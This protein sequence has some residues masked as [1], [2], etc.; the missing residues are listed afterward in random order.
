MDER[1]RE[2]IDA[3][4]F[5]L[6]EPGPQAEALRA[7]EAAGAEAIA[8]L[9]EARRMRDDLSAWHD[10]ADAFAE[11][12]G[13]LL[14]RLSAPTETPTV[15][16]APKESA[17]SEEPGVAAVRPVRRFGP[18][19]WAAAIAAAITLAVTLGFYQYNA[20]RRPGSL[21]A[22]VDYPQYLAIDAR[23]SIRV[24][25]FDAVDELESTPVAGA[26]VRA[27]L[28]PAGDDE[29]EFALGTFTTDAGGAADVAFST[30][31]F[32]PG[33]YRLV[34]DTRTRRRVA[35]LT[36][37]VML[38]RPFTVLPGTDKPV[39]RP[40]ETV[41]VRAVVLARP[42]GRP[43][44]GRLVRFEL[45]E[46]GGDRTPV[47]ATA[48]TGAFGIAAAELRTP[49]AYAPGFV[50][51]V[52]R[53]EDEQG[54]P[55]VS[56]VPIFV[57]E[58]ERP[59]AA[60]EL[61]P[62]KPYFLRG[63]AV[64]GSVR[65][66]DFQGRPLAGAAVSITL[67]APSV[68]A[69]PVEFRA[70]ADAG[71]NAAF[72]LVPG[73]AHRGEADPENP[74]RYLLRAEVRDV[75]GGRVLGR[76][77]RVITLA[78]S[79]LVIR[80]LP[81]GGRIVPGV[82]NR[83]LIAVA[84]PDGAPVE[85]EIEFGGVR[86]RAD[87]AT[88]VSFTP[89]E[90][91]PRVVITA[92]SGADRTRR[93]WSARAAE[94]AEFL[95][96]PSRTTFAAGTTLTADLMA[97]F[98]AG[99]VIVD[100]LH[101]EQWLL[102]GGSVEITAG[103]GR[104]EWDVPAELS[105]PVVLRAHRPGPEGEAAAVERRVVFVV[106]SNDVTLRLEPSQPAYRPGQDGAIAVTVRDAGG[107]AVPAAIGA[108]VFDASLRGV[109]EHRIEAL[110]QHL[111]IEDRLARGYLGVRAGRMSESAL[112]SAELERRAATAAGTADRLHGDSYDRYRYRF[113]QN[114]R[115]WMRPLLAGAFAAALVLLLTVGSAL[116]R[117]GRA[118][119][120][121]MLAASVAVGGFFLFQSR[122]IPEMPVR[123]V[124]PTPVVPNPGRGPASP[125]PFDRIISPDWQVALAQPA[126][127][128]LWVPELTT[129][130][131][132][133]ASIRFVARAPLPGSRW[134]GAITAITEDGGLGTAEIEI[135]VR[136]N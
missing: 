26:E 29:V 89:R 76:A 43:A 54:Y 67:A 79:P 73:D 125:G 74:R 111:S 47:S 39:Y 129:D 4:A 52:A 53:V 121:G 106:P 114:R 37:E 65:V 28:R 50:E 35:Q 34:V 113:E 18:W 27:A 97:A 105:G 30:A 1:L 9:E 112:A 87:G 117:A 80:V 36:R 131:H 64:E 115:G 15:A 92:V 95:L 98:P 6:L 83:V 20:V 90:P 110:Q 59:L 44:A 102:G 56:A 75:V 82:E 21:R 42:S 33:R 93:E 104:F 12:E 68:E 58:H 61:T 11:A 25:V 96:R 14:A 108:A 91:N 123:P 107:R 2:Q 127:S 5:G 128:L 134:T 31:G 49:A 132:G 45:R 7:I 116:P 22:Q 70:V 124:E 13:R 86:A 78:D 135:P 55:A 85:A 60:V 48:T 16:A 23:S 120:F 81:E 122:R 46:T 71:G 51:V 101:G 103:R 84:R 77:A 136:P 24:S 72:R 40:G 38:V 32:A 3:V 118:T 109:A 19:R 130:S 63:D 66:V 88:T 8:A 57:G 94:G 133:R 41:R 100:V 69:R 99:R 10:S 119:S 126:D 17:A 62:A